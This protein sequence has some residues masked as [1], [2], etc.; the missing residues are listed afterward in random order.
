MQEFKST[1]VQ[2]LPHEQ[3]EKTLPPPISFD[4]KANRNPHSSGVKPIFEYSKG[5]S[6]DSK[7][8]SSYPTSVPDKSVATVFQQMTTPTSNKSNAKPIVGGQEARDI[9][10]NFQH[11]KPG[12]QANITAIGG[13]TKSV[14]LYDNRLIYRMCDTKKM[15]FF[16]YQN[17][18]SEKYASYLIL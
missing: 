15:Q 14:G 9:E 10:I 11:V 17:F 1:P 3:K 5:K 6:S 13:A 8:D 16:S 12:V 4:F 7:F 18:E 2:V